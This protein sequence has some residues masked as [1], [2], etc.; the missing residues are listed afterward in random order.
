MADLG[1]IGVLVDT[2]PSPLHVGVISG[3]V[4]DALNQ[5]A[6][7]LVVAFHR[8]TKRVSGATVSDSATGEY[9]ILTNIAF[10]NDAHFVLNFSP[11]GSENIRAFDNITP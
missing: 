9:E 3:V 8:A 7:Q 1:A 10:K 4:R 5:P 6:A 11:D 2:G